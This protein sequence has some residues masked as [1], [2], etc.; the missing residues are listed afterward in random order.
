MC[1][2]P[3]HYFF[4]GEGNGR[5]YITLAR[6]VY[7]ATGQTGVLMCYLHAAPRTEAAFSVV[8][9]GVLT[10]LSHKKTDIADKNRHIFVKNNWGKR[11][12]VMDTSMKNKQL[13]IV[14]GVVKRILNTNYLTMNLN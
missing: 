3:A 12:Q 2:T 14:Q 10:S 1:R 8:S 6:Q 5:Q 13:G 4:R 11:I 7:V 9:S